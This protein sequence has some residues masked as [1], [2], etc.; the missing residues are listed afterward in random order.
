MGTELRGLMV[1]RPGIESYPQ[2]MEKIIV[3]AFLEP[4]K[5]PVHELMDDPGPRF[6][7]QPKTIVSNWQAAD[8]VCSWIQRWGDD[9]EDSIRISVYKSKLMGNVDMDALLPM[10]DEWILESPCENPVVPDAMPGSI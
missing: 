7:W 3:I 4:G 1:A 10:I 8:L 6:T 9:E 5:P 2:R